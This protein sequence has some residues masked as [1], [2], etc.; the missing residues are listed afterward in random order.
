MEYRFSRMTTKTL[1]YFIFFTTYLSAQCGQYYS[2]YRQDQFL[3][4][5]IFKNK[6]NGFFIEFGAYDGIK[7]SNTKFFEE[8]LGWKGI[9]LEPI[10]EHFSALEK[11]RPNSICI[12]GCIS[13]APGRKIFNQVT[14][15]KFFV[16]M[17]SGLKEEYDPIHFE[18]T[19]RETENSNG[20][21]KTIWVDCFTLNDVLE[22][23]NISHIDYLSIDTEG[24]ELNILKSI[25]FEKFNI[26]VIEVENNY[27]DPEF[28][29]FMES[30][31]YILFDKKHDETYVHV[32][33]LSP[34]N[35]DS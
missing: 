1:L 21:M 10:P 9:C 33:L 31:N 24:G 14:S 25:D 35:K 28:R 11:N 8:T 23:Y 32:K 20:S 27:S 3:N 30:K 7:F 22:R 17:L 26:D 12:Q 18:R 29:I 6:K 2:Q 16:E 5:N 19:K 4:E 13:D 15:K 34:N